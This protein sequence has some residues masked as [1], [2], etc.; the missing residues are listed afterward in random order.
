[1]LDILGADFR[2][3][4]C[5]LRRL[6]RVIAGSRAFR[7]ASEG[8]ADLVR[9]EPTSASE[10]EVLGRAESNCTRFPLVRLRPEQVVGSLRQSASIQPAD[11]DSHWVFRTI[12]FLQEREFVQDYGD[13]GEDELQDRGGTIPQRLLLL[14]GRRAHEAAR[15]DPINA[16]GRIAA[17]ASTD[18]KCV[19]AAYLVCLTRRP[20][21]GESRH[22][23]EQLRGCSTKARR[24]V[25]EDMLWSLYNSTEFSWNH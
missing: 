25:I 7:V 19:E 11:A 8:D 22:F 2:D 4:H 6:I 3:H 16:A 13:L 20:T 21:S 1:V 14:N 15:I 12:R 5:D 17:F 24:R 9:F 23:I 10:L 18:E